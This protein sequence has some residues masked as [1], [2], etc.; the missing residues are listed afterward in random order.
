MDQAPHCGNGH[1]RLI[2]VDS[3]FTSNAE[4]RYVPVKGEALAM[5]YRVHQ[6]VHPGK[7]HMTMGQTPN[8]W[9]PSQGK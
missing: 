8:P 4:S 7:S 1:W 3:W 6:G 9:S 5:V 2:L